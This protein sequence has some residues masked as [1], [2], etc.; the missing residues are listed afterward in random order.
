M[1]FKTIKEMVQLFDKMGVPDNTP[2]TIT[3]EKQPKYKKVKWDIFFNISKAI[4]GKAQ[5]IEI[6]IKEKE[7]IQE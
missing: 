2:V 1:F 5:E 7:A 6:K 4:D 3:V